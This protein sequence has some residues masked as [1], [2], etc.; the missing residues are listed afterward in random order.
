MK[1]KIITIISLFIIFSAS[2]LAQSVYYTPTS[3]FGGNQA[4]KDLIKSEMVYPKT[5]RDLGQEGTVK[6]Q[7]TV[8]K[9]GNVKNFNI[10]ESAGK[11]LDNEAIRL[12]RHLLW[13]PAQSKGTTVDDKSEIEIQFKL[14][15]YKKCVKQR[16][17]DE[18]E[19]LYK[20]VDESLAIYKPDELDTP[21][22]PLYK[23]DELKFADFMIQKIK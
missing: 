22:K 17:Y 13:T 5:A 9:D 7:F 8:A 2:I 10:I 11:N 21:P 12:F 15:K 19:Y 14:K 18:I 1:I 4:F 3:N 16:G 6:M 20:P 23:K